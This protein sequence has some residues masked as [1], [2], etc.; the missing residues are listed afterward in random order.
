MNRKAWEMPRWDEAR[1]FGNS[2][3][4]QRLDPAQELRLFARRT[5]IQLAADPASWSGFSIRGIEKLTR[6]A[7]SCATRPGER[8]LRVRWKREIAWTKTMQV[9]TP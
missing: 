1:E 6:G 2:E 5:E 7:G 9:K 8:L 3:P 4:G